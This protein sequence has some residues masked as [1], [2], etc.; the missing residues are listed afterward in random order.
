MIT[1]GEAYWIGATLGAFFMWL[2]WGAVTFNKKTK[3]RKCRG[4]GRVEAGIE[5]F[6]AN[7]RDLCSRCWLTKS[8]PPPPEKKEVNNE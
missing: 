1:V 2:L 3:P 7:G 8:C 6:I 4:C 5:V